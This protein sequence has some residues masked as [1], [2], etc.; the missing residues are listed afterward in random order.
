MSARKG[1]LSIGYGLH[2]ATNDTTG[3]TD[4]IDTTGVTDTIDT[5]GVNI[6]QVPLVSTKNLSMT[7]TVSPE[8][9]N[10]HFYLQQTLKHS[11]T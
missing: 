10:N 7:P 4:A 8:K 11:S 2:I 3:V 1:R 6:S 9:A 5:T